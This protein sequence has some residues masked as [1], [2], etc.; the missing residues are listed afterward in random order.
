MRHFS[1]LA[2]PAELFSVRHLLTISNVIIVSGAFALAV[3]HPA[4][5]P[6]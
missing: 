5:L 4:R 6:V 2:H 3:A 1:A